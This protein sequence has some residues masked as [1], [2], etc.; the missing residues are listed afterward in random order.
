MLLN[1]G[2]AKPGSPRT[3][4]L[5]LADVERMAR[6]HG[7]G[8]AWDA[9]TPAQR[10][11]WAARV[12]KQEDRERA[13]QQKAIADSAEK[14]SKA[15]DRFMDQFWAPVRKER[16]AAKRAAARKRKP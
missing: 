9:L 2:M 6:A 4:R 12:Q 5:T 14:A 7:A 13:A 11:L 1:G 15:F 16:A 10:K 3:K 8:D